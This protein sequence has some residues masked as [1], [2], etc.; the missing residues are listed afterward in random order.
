MS[1]ASPHEGEGPPCSPQPVEVKVEPNNVDEAWKFLESHSETTPL[2]T[3]KELRRVRRK[4]DFSVLPLLFACYMLH[5]ID[6][7]LLN[8][9]AYPEVS[10]SLLTARSIPSLTTKAETNS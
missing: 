1:F 7:A 2:A 6:K 9:R 10:W 4:A 8:V 5:F 3:T